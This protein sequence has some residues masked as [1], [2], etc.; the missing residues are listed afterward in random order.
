MNELID[1]RV[2]KVVATT[3]GLDPLEVAHDASAQT[4]AGWTSLA[5][6]HL[7][8]FDENFDIRLTVDDMTSMTSI[9]AIVTVL[10]AS[11]VDA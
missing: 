10:T 9:P 6:L 2:R 7:S 11:G 8:S 3:F 4:L 1:E 5:R